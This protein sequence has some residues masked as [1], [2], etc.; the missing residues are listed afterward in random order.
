MNNL[1]TNVLNYINGF[2]Q[3][4]DQIAWKI[5]SKYYLT[6]LIYN[7]LNLNG[8]LNLYTKTIDKLNYALK[9]DLRYINIFEL[10]QS[11]NYDLMKK[12]IEISNLCFFDFNAEFEVFTGTYI[13]VF[14]T[15]VPDYMI[16]LEHT[17]I[18]DGN[19]TTS[20]HKPNKNKVKINF[21]SSGKIKVNCREI[22]KRKNKKTVQYMM[23]IPEYYWNKIYPNKYNNFNWNQQVLC[24][25]E[26]NKKVFI[27]F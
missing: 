22:N 23:C 3:R 17:N 2:L 13:I 24:T 19:V 18:N 1:P 5:T 27:K 10:N 20:I 9:G 16:Y 26:I 4:T 6:N 15:S 25:N 8:E 21:N 11:S 14:L 7:I 12:Y